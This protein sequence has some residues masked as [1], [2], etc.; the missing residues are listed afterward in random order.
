MGSELLF[1]VIGVVIATAACLL[2]EYLRLSISRKTI[3]LIAGAT[4]GLILLLAAVSLFTGSS[5]RNTGQAPPMM[6][7]PATINQPAADRLPSEP[8]APLPPP[9]SIPEPITEATPADSPT[10][11]EATPAATVVPAA[12]ATP[13]GPTAADQQASQE[14]RQFLQEWATAWE[15]SAG[16]AGVSAP[17]LAMFSKDFMADGQ[18]RDQWLQNKKR[19]NR[20]K[21]WIRVVLHDI[22][23]T[24]APDSGQ[25]QVEFEQDYASSNYSEK[26]RKSMVLRQEDGAW[27]ILSLR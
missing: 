16:T 27:K 26:A 8:A 5:D 9:A 21:E 6:P 23:V 13:A 20:Q 1:L 11:P 17:Y 10:P 25:V 18:K 2:L 14:V 4:G 12:V 22:T 7:L 15:Q 19:I 24:N 3:L